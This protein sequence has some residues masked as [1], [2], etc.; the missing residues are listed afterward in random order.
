MHLDAPGRGNPAFHTDGYFERQRQDEEVYAPGSV[1]P[2]PVQYR[3]CL[4]AFIGEIVKPILNAISCIFLK[5]FCCYKRT[6]P[7][8]VEMEAFDSPGS[9]QGTQSEVE[10]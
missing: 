1:E 5:I 2:R 10:S 3:G 7:D 4:D 6:Q 9:D 8:P